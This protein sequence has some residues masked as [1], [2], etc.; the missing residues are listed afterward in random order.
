MA[1]GLY[2][3]RRAASTEMVLSR[4]RKSSRN[5]RRQFRQ[6]SI[7]A[8]VLGLALADAC[9]PQAACGGDWPQI[10]GPGRNGMAQAG[11]RLA[12]HWPAGRPQQAWQYDL[13]SGYAGPAVVSDRVLVFHRV[14]DREHLD[15]VS[16]GQGQRLWRA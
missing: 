6:V 3:Q 15:C 13:G 2:H 7:G 10:L 16:V 1:T 11:E 12:G 14:G 4:E 9:V 5:F 8:C